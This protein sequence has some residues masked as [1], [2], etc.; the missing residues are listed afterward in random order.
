MISSLKRIAGCLVTGQKSRR[1]FILI[2]AASIAIGIAIF[3][4]LKIGEPAAL[5]IW[6]NAQETIHT[7]ISITIAFF[8]FCLAVMWIIFPA[9]IY[10][11][12]VRQRA[13]FHHKA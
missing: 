4:M 13:A 10:F 1:L 5:R 12:F 6:P 9:I 11:R 3:V 7:S 2:V 8:G